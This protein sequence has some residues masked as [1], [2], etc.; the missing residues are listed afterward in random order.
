MIEDCGRQEFPQKLQ[1]QVQL[2]LLLAGYFHYR[3]GG[4]LSLRKS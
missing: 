3:L 4:A 1:V 2:L